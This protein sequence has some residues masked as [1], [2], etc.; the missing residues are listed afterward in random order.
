[1]K[2]KYLFSIAILFVLINACGSNKD[3]RKDVSKDIMTKDSVV[4][5]EKLPSLEK[6]F[7][8]TLNVKP[9]KDS[10]LLKFNF[11]KGKT[12]N[13]AMTFDM[14]QKKG[15]QSR[16][17]T[18]KW[19]YDMQVIDEKNDLKTIKTT[20][21]RI[22]MTMDMVNQKMEFSSEKQ[23]D[24]MDFMQLPS[25]MFG[26]IKGKSFTMQ[27]N[28]KG[29]VV[30]VS[31]FDK[32]GEAV[33]NEMN[34]PEDMK[35]MMRQNF[36]KQF[37]DDAVK[38]IFSQ[39]FEIYPNKHVK[40]G[41]SWKTNSTIAALKQDVATVYTVK[42]IKGNRVFVNG[43]SKLKSADGKSSGTQTSKLIIDSKTG[44]M[45]DGVFDQKSNDGGTSSKSRITGKEI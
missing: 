10:V 24:A 4:A 7:A 8:D 26:I 21:K 37:N 31:G 36:K 17:N 32:I 25:R 28:G 27:V 11:Q 42:N 12:Y 39:A 33:V 23:V 40:I 43:E 5:E 9:V 18:M 19:N 29:E 45:I 35:P 13:Y 38:Q 20:Y 15:D 22:D 2:A 14:N 3:D 41:D 34:L 30:S 44:L 16:A 6:E 1:M